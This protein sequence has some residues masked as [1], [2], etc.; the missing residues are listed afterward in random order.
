MSS[1]DRRSPPPDLLERTASVAAQQNAMERNVR[2]LP[3]GCRLFQV[4][5]GWESM[6]ISRDKNVTVADT[7]LTLESALRD[8]QKKV[9]FI[10][11]D[12]LMTD[13]DIEKLC[14]RNAAVKTLFKEVRKP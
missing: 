14:Q 13:A 11:L 5:Q 8:P 4:E 9:I 10:P 7:L 3:H 1:G 2:H 6:S 12:A